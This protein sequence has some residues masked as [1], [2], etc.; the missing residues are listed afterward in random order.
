MPSQ[1]EMRKMTDR[2]VCPICGNGPYHAVGSHVAKMHGIRAAELREM[3]GVNRSYAFV[4]PET[5]K[6]MSES[7]DK[8]RGKALREARKRG[9]LEWMKTRNR[10]TAGRQ[11]NVKAL[12]EYN[13][14]ASAIRRQWREAENSTDPSTGS[15]GRK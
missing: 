3:I 14:V 15:A 9:E 2:G 7:Y 10:T 5:S 11:A 13:K 1:E 4:S 6:R 12:V 8:E